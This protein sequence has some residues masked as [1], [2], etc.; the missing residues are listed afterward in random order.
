MKSSM[1]TCNV[2]DMNLEYSKRDKFETYFRR[3]LRGLFINFKTPEAKEWTKR[4]D[5]VTVSVK[6]VGRLF[7]VPLSQ[8][9]YTRFGQLTNCLA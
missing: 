2:Q 9:W 3:L 7:V 4:V 1:S 6:I 5:T 8:C